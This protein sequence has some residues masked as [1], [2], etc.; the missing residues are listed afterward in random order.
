[1]Y[2]ARCGVEL[3]KGVAACPLCGLR[4]YHPELPETPEAAPYPRYAEGENVRHGGLLFILSFLFAV[5]VLV[6]LLIDLKLNA[7]VTWSGY[8]GFGLLTAYLCFCLPLWFRR[9]SPVVF[10]PIAMA[11]LLGMALYVCLKTGGRWFLPLA[12]PA[13]GALLLLLETEIVLLRHC[14]GRR[15]HRALYI[16]GGGFLALGGL[17]IL[18]EFLLYVAFGIPMVWWSLIPLAVL[19]LLG[20]MLLIIGLCPPLRRSLHKRF[21][22]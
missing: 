17:C 19:G 18:I 20:L 11:A 21:F 5:P 15:R 12:L 6:C 4:A 14:V 16:L 8:V 10:F 1:M 3:Q 13:G 22:L 9:R 7:A 2:C